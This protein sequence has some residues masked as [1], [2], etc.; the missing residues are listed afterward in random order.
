MVPWTATLD[1]DRATVRRLAA[2][3][4]AE[5]RRRGIRRGTRALNCYKQ[6]VL[7]LRWFRDDTAIDAL[8]RGNHI[9]RATGYRY[10]DEGV[11]VL[12]N[13]A[14]TCARCSNTPAWPTQIP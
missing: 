6:A 5:R 11:H 1:V 3:L 13:Q 2:L 12:T 4:N 9:C 14:P 7:L 8:A 10:I